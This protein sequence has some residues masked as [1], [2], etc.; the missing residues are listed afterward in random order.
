ME[1]TRVSGGRGRGEGD[2]VL[3]IGDGEADENLE[4][5]AE[6]SPDERNEDEEGEEDEEEEG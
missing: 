3:W 2:R 5:A 1:L 6:L 4:E